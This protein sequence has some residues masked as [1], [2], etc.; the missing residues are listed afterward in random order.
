MY[1]GS[2][3]FPSN[4]FI[5]SRNW[6][7]R[8]YVGRMLCMSIRPFGPNLQLGSQTTQTLI[9]KTNPSADLEALSVQQ[10]GRPLHRRESLPPGD[11]K[12]V[13]RVIIEDAA[14]LL[15]QKL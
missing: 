11:G 2:S 8:E 13:E 15:L 1:S 6:V 9:N 12:G 7:K 10:P 4:A 5:K 3:S 14:K